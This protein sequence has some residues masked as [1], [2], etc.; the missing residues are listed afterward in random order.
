M[1][2]I[3]SCLTLIILSDFNSKVAVPTTINSTITAGNNR[4]KRRI[5]KLFSFIIPVSSNSFE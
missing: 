3:M 4:F 2:A 1:A 5:Q